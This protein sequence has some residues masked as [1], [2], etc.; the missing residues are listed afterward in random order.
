VYFYVEDLCPTCSEPILGV[1]YGPDGPDADGF[2]W[3]Q[4]IQWFGDGF[5]NNPQ[6][7]HAPR[8]NQSSFFGNVI[9]VPG[10]FNPVPTPDICFLCVLGVGE[11]PTI[12]GNADDFSATTVV[13]VPEPSMLWLLTLGVVGAVAR[14]GRRR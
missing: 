3:L 6:V 4:N 13:S 2:A 10:S 1:D 9:T 5:Y 12:S 7:L 14:R 11:D 8:A